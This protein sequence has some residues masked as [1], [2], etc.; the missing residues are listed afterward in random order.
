M[1]RAALFI[2]LGWS[3]CAQQPSLMSRSVTFKG[4]GA[5]G[6]G[7]GGT[8][9]SYLVSEDW[10]GNNSANW[11]IIHDDSNIYVNMDNTTNV[12]EGSESLSVIGADPPPYPISYPDFAGQ[13]DVWAFFLIKFTSGPSTD[14]YARD[15]WWIVDSGGNHLLTGSIYR[16]A[17][18]QYKFWVWSGSAGHSSASVATFNVNDTLAVWSR[19]QKGTGS[20][21]RADIWW[22][23]WTGAGTA[24]KPA[25]GSNWHVH[26]DTG[27][28]TTQATAIQLGAQH[29]GGQNVDA[30]YDHVRVSSSAIGDNPE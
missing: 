12:I 2:L 11:H 18:G 27:E 17:S 5:T 24:I 10:E 29:S 22:T 26:Y 13:D 23:P 6:S 1:L 3:V 7:G 21:E 16:Q 28:R 9:P 4:S 25:D 14:G 8:P 30:I 19:H 20:N 15:T